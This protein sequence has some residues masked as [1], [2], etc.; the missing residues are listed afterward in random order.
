MKDAPLM[1]AVFPGLNAKIISANIDG[2]KKEYLSSEW[3]RDNFTSMQ[4]QFGNSIISAA[5]SDNYDVIITDFAFNE[6]PGRAVA[7][8]PDESLRSELKLNPMIIKKL[9]KEFSDLKSHAIVIDF[10]P[11]NNEDAK[12]VIDLLP[13]S[14]EVDNNENK[15]NSSTEE[16][17]DDENE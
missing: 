15:N 14:K 6:Y 7:I 11:T 1:V 2:R 17:K 10:V 9:D 12:K 5:A 4:E 3:D 16:E 13:L 8:L